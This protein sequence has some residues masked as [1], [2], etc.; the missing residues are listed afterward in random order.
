[1]TMKRY[2]ALTPQEERVLLHKG[3]ESPGSG[4]YIDKTIDGI[5]LC[6]RCDHPLYMTS[7]QFS[8]HCG[9]PSFDE[10]L[11]DGVIEQR[12][13]DGRRIEVL[14]QSCGAHL[15]HLFQGEGFTPK[16][17]RY[18]I[19]SICLRRI[20]ATHPDKSVRAVFGAGCFWGVQQAFD[21]FPGVVRTR[22]GYMGG[23]VANPTYEEVCR[24]QTGHAEVVEV[25]YDPKVTSYD[26]LLRCF[27]TIHD[28][29]TYHR[30]GP[31]VGSQY[32]SACFYLT[33]SQRDLAETAI[34]TLRLQGKDVVTEVSPAKSF[35][36]A[37]DYH[38][39]YYKTHGL[40]CH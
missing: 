7:D 28:P 13:S 10:A 22:V 9:W 18:C 12:D 6:R 21:S 36:L 40:S 25:F 16:D 3:T 8:S 5:Y 4:E 2:H 17:A 11:P 26:A 24:G 37:E 39:D 29:T 20:E 34:A 38:Q 15:G 27:F 19:N 32:R 23:S 1:M 14:C 33:P 35:Y 30:Q 31:D